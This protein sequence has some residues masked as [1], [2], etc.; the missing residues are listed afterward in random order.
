MTWSKDGILKN[1]RS[2]EGSGGAGSENEFFCFFWSGMCNADFSHGLFESFLILIWNFIVH[3]V[4]KKW[5][6]AHA[7]FLPCCDLIYEVAEEVFLL[8]A[9][10]I[11]VAKETPPRNACRTFFPTQPKPCCRKFKLQSAKETFHTFRMMHTTMQ[12]CC[13]FCSTSRGMNSKNL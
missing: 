12:T 9:V 8:K 5:F 2:R 3:T 11:S 10:P 13:F 7:R 4:L 6:S 1:H